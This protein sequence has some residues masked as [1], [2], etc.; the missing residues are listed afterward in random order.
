MFKLAQSD[1]MRGLFRRDRLIVLGAAPKPAFVRALAAQWRGAA[2]RKRYL[3]KASHK[4][5]L[6]L[7]DYEAEPVHL[8]GITVHE[9]ELG[10]YDT[11]ILDADG[12]PIRFEETANPIGFVLHGE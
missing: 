5:N 1:C 6:R 11:G 4:Q 7:Y 3:F 8:V 9:P 12:E 2:M 10:I